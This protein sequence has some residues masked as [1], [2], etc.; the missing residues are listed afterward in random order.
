MAKFRGPGP[1]AFRRREDVRSA[2][3]LKA[4]GFEVVARSKTVGE[5]FIY[6]DIGDS[7][8][9]EGVSANEFNE[10]LKK[11]SGVSQ[12]DLH[13]DSDGGDVFQAETM[14]SRLRQHGAKVI[15][16]VD[17]HAASAASFLAMAGDDIV[18][19]EAGFMMIH[20]A[21]GGFWGRAKPMR[22]Y[23]DLIER[24]SAKIADVY[25][26]RTK[27]SVA[28]IREWMDE[29]EGLGHWFDAAEA[30]KFGFA[31]RMMENHR[32]AAVAHPEWFPNLPSALRPKRSRAAALLS[33]VRRI[34]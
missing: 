4:V 6:G 17:G 29:D 33:A 24:V 31:D 32:V 9:T 7:F 15:A 14:Y 5:I 30:M 1:A 2:D 20:D 19:A 34:P 13:I 23:A 26:A 22:A 25:A 18:I 8:W 12:I 3:A 21:A 16:F 11:L 27:Q 28:K 10:Q